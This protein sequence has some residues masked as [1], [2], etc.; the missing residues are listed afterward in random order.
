MLYFNQ[1]S[2]HHLKGA[3]MKKPLIPFT[4]KEALGAVG[5]VLGLIR[6]PINFLG[7]LGLWEKRLYND[8]AS[9]NFSQEKQATALKDYDESMSIDSELVPE[10]KGFDTYEG[11]RISSVDG[12]ADLKTPAGL[13]IKDRLAEN[14]PSATLV[15]NAINDA[16]DP[17]DA[18]K[19]ARAAFTSDMIKMKGFVEDPTSTYSPTDMALFV[20]EIRND[21]VKAIK[22]Q[23]AKELTAFDASFAKDD[24]KTALTTSLG[25]GNPEQVTVVKDQMRQALVKSQVDALK[26]FEKGISDPIVQL[27]NVAQKERD[28]VTFLAT[29]SANNK[30]MLMEIERLYLENK[31]KRIASGVS[32]AQVSLKGNRAIFKGIRV[33]DMKVISSITGRKITNNGNGS[34]QMDFPH[35]FFRPDY[36]S[37]ANNNTKQDLMS[38]VGAVRA[39]GS[40]TI[41]LDIENPTEKHGLEV[42]RQAYEAALETGFT[43]K[44]ITLNLNGK[45]MTPGELFADCRDRPRIAAGKAAKTKEA[46]E[47]LE[48]HGTPKFED[49]KA[50]VRRRPEAPV[51]PTHPVPGNP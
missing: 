43:E 17:S 14:N 36:Y 34:F 6:A 29:M 5:S 2:T 48:K 9:E 3:T 13:T 7:S 28:R 23:H 31:D 33:E 22:D 11:T 50:E 45:K 18:T 4:A 25:L 20:T 16:L 1:V 47:T 21:A 39:T 32:A 30:E 46:W 19:R 10:S 40:D 44:N 35:H 26:V 38:L 42:L 41:I 15:S 12:F 37:S 49:M 8:N 27:H 24:F 51:V